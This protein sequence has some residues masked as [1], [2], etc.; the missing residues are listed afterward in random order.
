MR[1]WAELTLRDRLLALAAVLFVLAWPLERRHL[2]HTE[3]SFLFGRFQDAATLAFYASDIAFLL[4]LAAWLMWKRRHAALPVPRLVFWSGL[5]FVSWA[6][7]RTLPLHPSL[8]GW[9]GALRVAQGFLVLLIAADLFRVERI[10]KCALVALVVAGAAQALLGIAQT[11]RGSAL[12]L[13]ALGEPPIRLDIPGVAKVDVEPRT[14]Q[15]VKGPRE[16]TRKVLRSYGTLPHPNALAGFLIAAAAASALTFPAGSRMTRS[17]FAF[18]ATAVIGAGIALSYSRSAWLA[19][20]FPLVSYFFFRHKTR[21]M[22]IWLLALAAGAT[23]GFLAVS[24]GTR[25]AVARFSPPPS[26]RFLQERR[27]YGSDAARIFTLRSIS[28]VGT[29][30]YLPALA[31]FHRSTIDTSNNVMNSMINVPTGTQRE[32]WQYEGVHAVPLYMA[33]ETGAVGLILF[34]LSLLGAILPAFAAGRRSYRN[35][36]VVFMAATVLFVSDKYPWDTQQG[37]ILLWSFFGAVAAT[38]YGSVR[39]L[40]EQTPQRPRIS[41]AHVG[42]VEHP[43]QSIQYNNL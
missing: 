1:W 39:F 30:A 36:A 4:L 24:E 42:T 7:V 25:A 26:D 6:F 19:L 14:G 15:D 31:M 34:S 37:R 5:A 22:S 12:G 3:Y 23:T 16:Q 40:K 29:S 41:V 17:V 8:L 13:T 11:T 20:T 43:G 2:V 27:Q 9:Y 10:R 28:G 38:S 35:M 33:V 21:Q 32:P 18:L